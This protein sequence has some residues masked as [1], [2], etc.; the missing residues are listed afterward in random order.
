M[1]G[2]LDRLSNWLLDFERFG[3]E[4][5]LAWCSGYAAFAL[6]MGDDH[7][8]WPSAY[9]LPVKLPGTQGTWATLMG[10]AFLCKALG[11]L[12][13]VRLPRGGYFPRVI[14]LAMSGLLW[15]SL[16]AARL[17][18]DPHTLFGMPVLMFGMGAWW[19]L[20]R[21]PSIRQT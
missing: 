20:L 11:L 6:G 21:S 3:T 14:G 2:R 15:S 8:V 12:L 4:I 10:V 18:D 19:V 13:C 17:L 9:A 1:V 16:G 5:V 7:G